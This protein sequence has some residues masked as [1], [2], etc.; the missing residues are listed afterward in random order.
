MQEEEHV[1]VSDV[2]CG[3]AHSLALFSTGCVVGWGDNSK[4]QLGQEG[5]QCEGGPTPR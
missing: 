2:V 3:H 1:T 5:I 4:E